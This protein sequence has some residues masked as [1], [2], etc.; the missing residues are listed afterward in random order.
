MVFAQDQVVYAE[1][2]L[3]LFCSADTDLLVAHDS[4]YQT[5][6]RATAEFV[7]AAMAGAAG[8]GFAHAA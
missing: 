7:V 3:L 5:L 8:T 1:G 2:G 4:L 6:P